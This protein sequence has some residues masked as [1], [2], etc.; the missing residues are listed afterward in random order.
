MSGRGR[1]GRPARP[2]REERPSREGRP[3]QSQDDRVSEGVKS[4]QRESAREPDH[5]SNPPP[6]P[7]S[8]DKD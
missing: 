8:S 7:P 2:S 5:D 6:P 1:S 3:K 4:T